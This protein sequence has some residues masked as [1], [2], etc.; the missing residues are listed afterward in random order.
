MVFSKTEQKLLNAAAEGLQWDP[1][2]SKVKYSSLLEHSIPEL[3]KNLHTW[4]YDAV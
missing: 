3:L 1:G 4:M 2:S